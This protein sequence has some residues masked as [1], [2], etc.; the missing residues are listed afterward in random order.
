MDNREAI[1]RL[2]DHFR[3]HDDG[4]P[5]P[6]LDKA[7]SM[8]IKA[9]EKQIPQKVVWETDRTWGIASKTPICPACDHGLTKVLFISDAADG[10]KR[11]TYCETC[12]Q[13]IDWSE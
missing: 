5:T 8:A 7:V 4:R 13:A 6:K 10:F 12:G 9:L 2:K 11:V 1:R 3:I